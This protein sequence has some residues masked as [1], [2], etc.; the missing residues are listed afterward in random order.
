MIV[1]RAVI[2]DTETTDLIHTHLLPL[3]KQPYIT[4]FYGVEIDLNTGEVFQEYETLVKPPVKITAQITKITGIDDELVKDAPEFK[5]V[6]SNIL[7]IL[8]G[9]PLVVAH[10]ASFDTEMIEIELERLSQKIS[11]P[12][13]ICSVEQTVH[14]LGYRLSLQNLH[15][16]LFGDKFREAHR[17]KND[18]QALC[19]CCVRLRELGEI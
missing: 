10:N 1:D 14:I 4:E 2:F 19:K 17:A 6:A 12:R 9:A 11:W 5:D 13:L 18:V 16:H 3:H 15:Q 7:N 8:C